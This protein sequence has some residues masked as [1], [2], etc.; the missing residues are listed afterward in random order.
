[1][2]FF[3]YMLSAHEAEK[4]FPQLFAVDT[5]SMSTANNSD[6]VAP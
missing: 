1:M 3:K 6:S 2:I 4:S 5:D